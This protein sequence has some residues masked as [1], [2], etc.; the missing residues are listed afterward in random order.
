[1]TPDGGGA[2]P[3]QARG[4]W[5]AA[6]AEP[7]RVAVI[8]PAGRAWTAGE[9]GAAANKLVH[10]LRARGTRAGDPL[11]LLLPNRAETFVVLMA[12][13][14]A[15]WN[16]VP[17]NTNLT[18]AEITYILRDA[19]A[20]ALVA[21]ARFADV[22]AEAA[23]EAGVLESG[24]IA[25]GGPIPGGF[26]L[27][28]DVLEG[29]PDTVPED[30]VAGQF[31]Q[32]TSGTTGRP[33]AVERALP[34]FDPETWVQVFSGNLTRYDIEPG[35][36][37]VHLITSPM[38]H[39]SPLSFGYFSA[40]FEH[41]VVLMEKW[42]AEEALRLIERHRVTDTAMVPTQLHRL[43]Q[44]P[45]DVRGRYDVSSLRQVIHAAAP[46][47]MDLKLRLFDWLGPVIYE[48]YGATEG[49]GTL[50]RPEEWLAH[51]GTVGRPWAGA[52]IKVLDDEGNEVGPGVV[53]T[54]YM[55]LMGGDF[56]YKGDA[57]K[58]NANRH[59]DFFTVGD[60]GEVDEDGFLY[61]RDRKIDM[62]ISGGVNI[63]PAEVEAALLSHP[64]V[65]DAAVFGIPNEEWGE[66]V[67][68]VV[69]PAAG[70]T[71]SDGL[72]GELAA[73]C[74]TL[75]A[76]YKC[77]RSIDFTEAMP[78]DPNGK[79]YKRRLRDPYWEGHSSGI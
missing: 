69:E 77:P 6:Q 66:E 58:T 65:G 14:Q 50:A 39:M 1:M 70:Y 74:A 47:P 11:A 42:D 12:L 78:R 30:R 79:L 20:K 63:Y 15:G 49:G 46:M 38:Y 27:L 59:G 56:R 54:V 61:L 7:E 41:T 17:L 35:G 24:R 34:S 33:K 53:G 23:A 28:D 64:A 18:A 16:F 37:A 10:A 25:V 45:E 48:F 72:A 43:M 60:M 8:D 32:Y 9:I 44:L 26:T 55:K 76:K 75:L 67:K 4:F 29:Q 52:D 36:D 51:P 3:P 13:F 19:G 62:I 5:A 31:M 73:H 40:H 22:A 57:E 2:A 71:A 68:A 21:D